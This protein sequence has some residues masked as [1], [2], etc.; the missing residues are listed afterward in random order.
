LMEH[1]ASLTETDIERL[2]Q[3]HPVGRQSA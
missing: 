1:F 3:D 2:A